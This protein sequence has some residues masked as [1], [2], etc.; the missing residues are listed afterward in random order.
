[1]AMLLA[2]VRTACAQTAA[3]LFDVGTLREIRLLVNSGISRC[4]RQT[5]A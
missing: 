5:T 2:V 4:A 1:M 3:D